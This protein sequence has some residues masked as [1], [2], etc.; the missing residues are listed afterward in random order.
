MKS[1]SWEKK[2][3][4][5]EIK[6]IKNKL[7]TE[8]I[9]LASSAITKQLLNTDTFKK[10]KVVMCYLS[11]GNEVNTKNFIKECQSL[12][13]RI[14]A[15]VIIKNSDGIFVMEA[16][17]IIDFKNE[18]T[19]GVMGIMEPKKQ[20]QR[21]TNPE[22]ID[23]I[24]IPGLAFDKKGNRLGYGGGYYDYFLTRT[25][26]DS[27]KI[28]IAYTKQIINEVPIEEHDT[29]VKNILTEE[30]FINIII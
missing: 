22:L 21:L 2:I 1:I 24:V 7:T 14:L 25:R 20:F 26:L 12:N 9:N 13:K 23:F 30:G 11:F 16:S 4:R 19:P 6:E 15:P 3:L 8:Y 10:A 28:A 27:T 29:P 18:L 5:Q 17:E